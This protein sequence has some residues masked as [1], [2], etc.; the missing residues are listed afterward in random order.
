MTNKEMN[1]S[2]VLPMF[3]EAENIA[4]TIGRLGKLAEAICGS[5]EIVVSDDASTDRSADIVDGLAAKDARIRL[6]RLTKNSNFGG[7]LNAGLRAASKDI[8][9]YT[10]SDLPA[11]EEDIR[12]A[13]ELLEGADIVTAYSLV[14]KDSSFKRIVMSKVYNF[15]VQLLFGLSLLDINSGLKVYRRKII[16]GME[17]KSESPFIDVEIFAEALK[18]G[19]RIRQYGLI[20]DLRTKGHSSISRLG[21]VARTFRDMCAYKFSK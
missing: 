17:L 14:I 1:V 8:V 20:F 7:A 11:K 6:V 15:L 21:V 19:A 18:R 13:I 12:K 16:E 3:N 10:D 5:Y 9:V 4:A 2:F